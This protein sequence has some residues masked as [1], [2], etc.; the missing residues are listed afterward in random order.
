MTDTIIGDVRNISFLIK[1]QRAVNKLELIA[2]APIVFNSIGVQDVFLDKKN[3]KDTFKVTRGTIL[4]YFLAAKDS[5]LKVDF[6]INKSSIPDISLI[7]SSFDLQT[8]PLFKIQPRTNE[9]MPMPFVTN[10][11]VITLQKLKL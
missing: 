6:T 4:S 8:N 1:P 7:E 3:Q 5:V 9:M 10:D 2:N 11:A